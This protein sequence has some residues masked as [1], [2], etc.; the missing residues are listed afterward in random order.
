LAN[1]MTNGLLYILA[2]DPAIT[3]IPDLAGRHV[4]VPFRGDT[5]EIIL[6]QLLA[7]HGLDAGSDLEITYAGT[8][9]EAMQLMLAGRVEAA[10]TSEPGTTAGEL[11]GRQE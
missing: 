11:R 10:L 1:A 9:T 3:A 7:H 5:P 4:A 2:E 8:P 6:G